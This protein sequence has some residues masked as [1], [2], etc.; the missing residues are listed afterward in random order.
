MGSCYW[1]TERS[2]QATSAGGEGQTTAAMRQ[3]GTYADWDFTTVWSIAAER[4]EGYPYLQDAG[5]WLVRFLAGANGVV[6]GETSQRVADA[7][8]ASP[9]TAVPAYAFVFAQWS[10]GST[11]NP[12]TLAAVYTAIELTASFRPAGPVATATG[13]FLAVIGSPDV[14]QGRGLWDLSGTYATTIGGYPLTLH[15]DADARGRTP[16]TAVLAGIA[17]GGKALVAADLA[18]MGTVRTVAGAPRLRLALRGAD[19]ART[20]RVNLTLD[21]AL[22]RE[23]RQLRGPA[24]GSIR[25]AAETIPVADTLALDLPADVDGTWMLLFDL[26]PRGRASAGTAL[27]ALPNGAEYLFA[28]VGRPAGQDLILSL[29]GAATDPAAQAI[30]IRATVTPLEGGWAG[31]AAFSALGYRQTLRW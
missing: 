20:V 26:A 10:D 27:L 11:E 3:A 9:V 28:V 29:S 21:L 30:G 31:L 25:T 4:N 24:A 7:Q 2:R 8:G 15:L 22:D 16:G 1:D 18:V 14:E 23:A 13:V 12:R 6:I 19:T 5:L 17:T